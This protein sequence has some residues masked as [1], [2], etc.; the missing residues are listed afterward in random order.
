MSMVVNNFMPAGNALPPMTNR[1][2]AAAIASPWIRIVMTSHSPA[3]PGIVPEAFDYLLLSCGPAPSIGS[4]DFLSPES[5]TGT[6]HSTMARKK[7]AGA[8]RYDDDVAPSCSPM[9][10][11]VSFDP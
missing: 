11:H 2:S 8:G 3:W 9:R 6:G 5:V 4:G 1:A 7:K 10:R